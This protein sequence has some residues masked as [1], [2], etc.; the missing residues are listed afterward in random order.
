MPRPCVLVPRENHLKPLMPRRAIMV[1]LRNSNVLIT[2]VTGLIGGEIFRRLLTRVGGGYIWPLV[3]PT[4]EQT[5]SERLVHRLGRSDDSR[6]IPVNV[7]PVA[8]DVQKP[9]W[10]LS[11]A[12]LDEI[13][14]DVNLIIHNAADTS[15][16][17]HR[18]TSRTN[19]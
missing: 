8:G 7:S 14:S 4:A 11:R 16:V 9:N 19:I 18:D 5:I 6:D 2:G 13:S 12:D 1:R 10:G 17:S 15:F 3:R